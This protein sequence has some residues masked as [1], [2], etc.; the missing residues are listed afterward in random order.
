MEAAKLGGATTIAVTSLSRSPLTEIADV[1]LVA[2]SRE[3]SFQLEAM[4]G[5]HVGCR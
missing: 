3:L 2:G 4:A 5:S 1:I